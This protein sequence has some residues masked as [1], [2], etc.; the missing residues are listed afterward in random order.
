M[1]SYTCALQSKMIGYP[2]FVLH[3][4]MVWTLYIMYGTAVLIS[5]AS[6]EQDIHHEHLLVPF[7]LFCWVWGTQGIFTLAEYVSIFTTATWCMQG[8]FSEDGYVS[9]CDIGH[10]VWTPLRYHLGTCVF[11][12]LTIGF[13]RPLQL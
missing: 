3:L 10:A 7:Y 13:L 1:M 2:M 5:A 8:G 6:T 4:L 9:W 12:G 11:G